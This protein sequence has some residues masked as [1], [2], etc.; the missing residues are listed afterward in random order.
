VRG[1]VQKIHVDHVEERYTVESLDDQRR[2]TMRGLG[3]VITGSILGLLAL[4]SG[5]NAVS[6]NISS[7]NTTVIPTNN[8]I[9]A[10]LSSS[11]TFV[12]STS[13]TVINSQLSP[14][15]GTSVPIST[16]YSALSINSS[17]FGSATYSCPSCTTFSFLWGSPDEYNSVAFYGSANGTGSAIATFTGSSLQQATLH[18]G[19]DVVTFL[20]SQGSFSSVVLSNS[21]QAAF[22]YADISPVP[23]PVVGAGLPGIAGACFALLALVRRRRANVR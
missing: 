20:A 1:F 5:A 6:I 21:G 14:Y 18:S 7:E 4:T 13:G 15:Q 23:G 10:P 12:Q 2:L 17:G 22:E 8:F 9:T 16:P 19:F 11:G 3:P